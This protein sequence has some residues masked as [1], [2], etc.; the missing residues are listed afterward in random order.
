[1]SKLD[2]KGWEIPDQTPVAIPAHIKFYDTRDSIRDMIRAELS[3]E[4]RENGFETWEE[5]DDF[6]V[7]DDY[8]PTSP[9]E[10]QFDPQGYSLWDP[11]RPGGLDP[12]TDPSGSLRSDSGGEPDPASTPEGE[13]GET[14]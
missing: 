10:E 11:N 12:D 8:D 14:Q 6:D 7:G 5:S 3:R 9:Y 2:S 4:A 1:M 13:N